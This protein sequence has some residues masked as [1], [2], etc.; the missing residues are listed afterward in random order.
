MLKSCT[1]K[2]SDESDEQGFQFTFYCDS[3]GK[4]RRTP[5]Y[6]FSAAS[7]HPES[8]PSAKALELTYHEE[9]EL[10]YEQVNKEADGYYQTCVKCGARIC[11]DCALRSIIRE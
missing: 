7:L 9:R 6:P 3:C 8:E 1:R 10:V 5:K 2:Y 11:E 4:A